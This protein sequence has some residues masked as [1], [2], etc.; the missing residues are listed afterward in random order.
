[1]RAD[2][3]TVRQVASFPS[4]DRGIGMLL[5]LARRAGFD[6]ERSDCLRFQRSHEPARRQETAVHGIRRGPIAVRSFVR[7]VPALRRWMLASTDRR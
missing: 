4:I 6:A 3:N 7:L 5:P 2:R 1:M